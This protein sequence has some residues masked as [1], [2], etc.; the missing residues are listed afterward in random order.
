MFLYRK[1]KA[2]KKKK[3]PVNFAKRKT[4]FCPFCKVVCAY[5]S[6]EKWNSFLLDLLDFVTNMVH[7]FHC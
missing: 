2:E 1:I 5:C 6:C 7:V 3:K 4:I